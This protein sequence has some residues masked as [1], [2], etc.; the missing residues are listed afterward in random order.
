MNI[1]TN[2]S[3]RVTYSPEITTNKNLNSYDSQSP[4]QQSLTSD[5]SVMDDINTQS[6]QKKPL[7][8]FFPSNRE[9]EVSIKQ[10]SQAS[11]TSVNY[12]SY[13]NFHYFIMFRHQ[14]ML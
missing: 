7:P 9:M 14:I 13:F 2:L 11:T 12:F 4:V 5:I 6:K 3:H 1:H 8:N 10:V